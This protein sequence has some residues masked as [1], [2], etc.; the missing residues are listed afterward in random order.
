MSYCVICKVEVEPFVEKCPLCQ[1]NIQKPKN[2]NQILDGKAYPEE[3]EEEEEKVPEISSKRRQLI[4]WEAT[5]VAAA[6]PI[7]I[8]F[9]INMIVEKAFTVTWSRYPVI[10]IVLVWLLITIPLFLHKKPVLVIVG[11]T[12]SII[13]FLVLIDVFDGSIDWYYQIAL[14]II[15]VIVVITSAVVILSLKVKNKGANIGAFVLFGVSLLCLGLDFVINT[16]LFD[17]ET[18]WETLGWSFYVVIPSVIIGG[19]LLYLHYR[20]TRVVDMKRV[21]EIRKRLQT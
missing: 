21:L 9:A 14:P 5:S 16:T 7:L 15:G 2:V 1:T 4:T 13:V 17:A 10:G 19:F 11:E 3:I 18:I 6:V 20:L 8:I 12:L